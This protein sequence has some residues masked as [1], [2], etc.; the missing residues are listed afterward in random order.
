MKKFCKFIFGT[1]TIGAGLAGIFYA[2]KKFVEKDFADDFDDDFDEDFDDDFDIE[3]FT[4]EDADLNTESREY[5]SIQMDQENEQENP[6]T[7]DT[8]D[9]E[10]SYDSEP[11]YNEESTDTDTSYEE[12]SDNKDNL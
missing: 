1:L 8:S 12:D 10:K 6:D 3:A 4:E 2:Y 11:S 5:V 9:E 7:T